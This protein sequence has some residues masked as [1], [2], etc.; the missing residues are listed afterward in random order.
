MKVL[1]TISDKDVISGAQEGEA[2]RE[3]H[4]ARAV[5]FDD[6]NN[7]ALLFVSKKHY[8]KLPGGG[9]EEGE[10]IKTGL[11]R[12]VMEEVGCKIEVTGEIGIIKE[13]RAKFNE[14]QASYCYIAKIKEKVS[15]PKFTE[16]EQRE[17]FELKWVSLDEAIELLKNDEPNNYVGKFIQ[18]RDLIFLEK[19]K[20]VIA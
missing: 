8:H 5:I 16:E 13:K 10:D 1:K 2:T 20:E 15:N 3:R 18:M 7:I 17:G 11:E 4:A 19:A 12:E 6:Q 14:F 9:I